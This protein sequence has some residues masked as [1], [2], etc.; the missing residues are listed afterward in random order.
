[1]RLRAWSAGLLIVLAACGDDGKGP[2]YSDELR[3]N[4][5]AAC[6]ESSSGEEESCD[7]L[8]DELES[9]MTEDEYRALE[10]KGEDAFLADDRVQGALAVCR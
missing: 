7:C 9:R 6:K 1:M 3:R 5:L 4:F 2:D 10:D 8:I